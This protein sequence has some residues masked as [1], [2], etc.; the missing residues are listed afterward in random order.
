[1]PSGS[2]VTDEASTQNARGSPSSSATTRMCS[3]EAANGTNDAVP[4]T[5]NPSPAR[6]ATG[7]SP[8]RSQGRGA[9]VTMRPSAMAPSHRS[10]CRAVPNRAT[11]MPQHA[12]DASSGLGT[13]A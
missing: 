6:A 7:P 11:G 4:D 1:M 10:F 8:G 12:T 9:A 3:A 13:C 5:T 2:S